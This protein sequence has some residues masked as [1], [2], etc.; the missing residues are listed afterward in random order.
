MAK[1]L[2]LT[3][4]TPCDDLANEAEDPLCT[5]QTILREIVNGQNFQIQLM[6]G[7]KRDLGL[8]DVANCE[9]EIVSRQAGTVDVGRQPTDGIDAS[10]EAEGFFSEDQAAPPL[11]ETRQGGP[12]RGRRD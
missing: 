11:T 6:R 7:I 12:F 1:A 9:L 5:M 8:S 2:L 4:D 3:G 10:S